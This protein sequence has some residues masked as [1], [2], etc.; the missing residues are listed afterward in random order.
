MN[1][2]PP[3]RR[4]P[5]P[6]PSAADASNAVL[7]AMQACVG[8]LT[9]QGVVLEANRVMREAAGGDAS[10]IIGRAIW[11]GPWW[12]DEPLLR[13]R[14]RGAVACAARG[15]AQRLDLP[16]RLQD[17]QVVADLAIT[18][19]RDAAGRVGRLVLTGMDVS[20]RLTL[21]QTLAEREARLE[22]ALDAAGMH[23]WTLN[24]D[25]DAFE[26]PTV[27]RDGSALAPA[28]LV[29]FEEGFAGIHPDDV[30]RCKAALRRAV[31]CGGDYDVTYRQQ[32]ETD[33]QRWIRTVA[34]RVDRA[35][36]SGRRLMVGI[37]Q[38][39]TSQREATRALADSEERFRL[40]VQSSALGT[41]DLDP[42]TMRVQWSESARRMF[43]IEGKE[44]VALAD[45][46]SRMHPDDRDRVQGAITDALDP[47]GSGDYRA[48]YR[49]VWPDGTVRWMDMV[50]LAKFEGEGEA[51]YPA[52]FA[53]LLWDVTEQQRLIES[54]RE[55][56]ARKDEF[57]AMLAHELRNPLA[58]LTNAL[59]LIERT[60]PLS[61]PGRTA[62]EMADRQR[63]QMQRLVDDLLEVGRITRGK[64]ALKPVQMLVASAV[65]DA[66]EAV[67]SAIEAHG[68]QLTVNLPPTPSRIVADP[69]RV[70]Q[71]LQNLLNNACKY[72]PDGGRIRIDVE[73]HPD[74]VEIRVADDGDGIA[75]DHLDRIF[76]LF[77]QADATY[78]RAAG[79][80]GIGLAL[81]KRLVELHGGTV[82]ADSRGK[83]WGATFTVRLP[84]GDAQPRAAH[85]AA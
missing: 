65:Y 80:L 54:L 17:R 6:V 40:A 10:A 30:Q 1:D 69:A 14:V 35:G 84:R 26:P 20:A 58:P 9:P 39:I 61:A 5:P 36:P 85:H 28:A 31:A 38:D 62:L 49:V 3:E 45:P 73:D 34:R 59:R 33:G 56:D 12:Q 18:P 55:A 43:G 13:E 60:E 29:P 32:D 22:L 64:I 66:V 71:V 79:G 7:D 53:G 77:T 70:A 63:R 75:P 81:V 83:G 4:A 67:N 57:L 21:E 8:V 42:K 47:A 44:F 15:D 74:E 51:R 24:V 78:D 11:D 37:A 46:V 52:R 2:R 23:L 16:C 48:Q 50:G 72:T 82:R 68:H 76:D 41:W 25:A 19:L 27:A